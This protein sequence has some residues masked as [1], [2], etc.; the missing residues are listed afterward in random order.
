MQGTDKVIIE[1][2][3]GF[4]TVK[5]VTINP[6]N[7]DKLKLGWKVDESK[8]EPNYV[9]EKSD[10][11]TFE[12]YNN[13][14]LNFYFNYTNG[15]KGVFNF[16]LFLDSRHAGFTNKIDEKILKFVDIK[17]NVAMGTSLEVAAEQ[18]NKWATI[19]KDGNK[20]K[21][22][23]PVEIDTLR[24][25][26]NGEDALLSMVFDVFN[27]FDESFEYIGDINKLFNGD[28]SELQCLIGKKVGCLLGT[29]DKGY[30]RVYPVFGKKDILYSL[31][32]RKFNAKYPYTNP[33]ISVPASQ[34]Q[35]VADNVDEHDNDI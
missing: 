18:L 26:C 4:N 33:M 11:E 31:P 32:K 2:N 17:G 7:A 19:D 16:T 3:V 8:D 13:C 29:D 14:R 5:I 15:V 28:F 35:V 1:P 12:T 20:R 6:T 10:G 27:K 23:I 24:P 22:P 34:V 9:E 25:M 21:K 30:L